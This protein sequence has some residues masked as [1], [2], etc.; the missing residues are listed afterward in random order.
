VKRPVHVAILGAGIMGS[1]TALM[2]AQK[3]VSSTLFDAAREP[4]SRASRWNEGKIHLGFLYA[5][6]PTLQTARRLLPGGLAFK[7]L[8]ERLIGC[9]LDQQAT[10]ED[11]IFLVHDNS[12]VSADA[13]DRYLCA[14]AN[15]VRGVKEATGYLVDLSDCMI[16]S[17]SRREIERIADARKISAAFRVPERSVSTNWI[18][19]RYVEAISSERRIELKLQHRVTR[20]RPKDGSLSGQWIVETGSEVHGPYDYVVNALWEGKLFVDSTVDLPPEWEW[21]H[22]YRLSLFISTDRPNEAANAAVI[23]GPFG[24]M[25]NYNGRDFYLS[26]YLAGLVAEDHSIQPPYSPVITNARRGQ[27]EESIVSELGAIIPAASSIYRQKQSARLEG[28]WVFAM[29]A[30]ALADPESTLHR[31]DRIGLRRAGTY[32]SV[33][34]G[35]YSM[36][37][38]LAL[39]V[40]DLISG[41]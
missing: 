3:G 10:R 19:D 23:I 37:P 11:E 30:G 2:L 20:V 8:V 26:W 27:I 4:M 32:I 15:L 36:A 29:G 17:L 41:H 38:W 33:D 40:V 22:R 1:T 14:V 28:G 18:A 9:S 25:K 5:A 7:G 24:D 13:T 34:T 39:K 21:S 31:R 12:V 6:D 35:K 16:E